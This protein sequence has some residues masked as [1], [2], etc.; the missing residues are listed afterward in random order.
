MYPYFRVNTADTRYTLTLQRYF[1]TSC[2]ALGVT[3]AVGWIQRS[4]IVTE[5]TVS[6][7]RFRKV[8]NKHR[9]THQKYHGYWATG[10]SL[11]KKTMSEKVMYLSATSS[12]CTQAMFAMKRV[13][14]DFANA[15]LIFERNIWANQSTSLNIGNTISSQRHVRPWSR[16]DYVSRLLSFK[17]SA[18]WFAKPTII[19]PL[20]C[21]RHG[22]CNGSINQL[23]CISCSAKLLHDESES[24]IIKAISLVHTSCYQ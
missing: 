18:A 22:W 15:C 23:H 3:S 14:P 8:G 6:A 19:S 16:E 10:L 21:A 11:S 9:W 7:K 20:Q 17:H 12:S 4:L 2:I 5:E 24:Q 13:R 1:Q